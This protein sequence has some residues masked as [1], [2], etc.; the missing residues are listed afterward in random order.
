M[1][2]YHCH[3]ARS[4]R[5]LWTLY[6][7]EVDCEIINMEFPP[8]YTFQG[9][10]SINPLGTVPTLVDGNNDDILIT[11]SSA[12]AMYLAEKYTPN[13]LRVDPSDPEYGAYLNW[14]FHSDATLTF[15]QTL[16]LRYTQLEPEE[17]RIEQVSNDYRKWFLAR[18]SLLKNTLQDGREFLVC[19]RFTIADICVSYALTLAKSLDINE[20]FTPDI[21]AWYQRLCERDAHIKATQPE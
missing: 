21:A 15:P 11:E 13:L 6:E 7:L 1:K 19:D 12:G 4:L 20:A 3:N 8:R 10:K 2:L 18:L 5:I 17:R 14:L 16:V 9:Y